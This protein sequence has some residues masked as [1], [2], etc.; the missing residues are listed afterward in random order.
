MKMKKIVSFIC[1]AVISASALPAVGVSAKTNDSWKK[2]YSSF[3]KQ[4]M[5]KSSGEDSDDFIFERG[6]SVQDL[7]SDGIPELMVSDGEWHMAQCSIYTYLGGNKLKKL[8]DFGEYGVAAFSPENGMLVSGYMGMGYSFT[9]FYKLEN[10]KFETIITFDDDAGAVETDPTFKIDGNKVS[11]MYYEKRLNEYLDSTYITVGNTFSLTETDIKCALGGYSSYKTA[12]KKFLSAKIP[13]EESQEVRYFYKKDLTG[14]GVPE[15][16]FS[17]PY[18]ECKIFTYAD[19]R[20]QLLS[21]NYIGY[22]NNSVG[23]DSSAK[24]LCFKGS[25]DYGISYGF[26]SVQDGKISRLCELT[27]YN[28]NNGEPSYLLNSRTVTASAYSSELKKYQGYTFK[29]IGKKYTVSASDISKA[30]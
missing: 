10:N 11:Q 30:F 24:I 29:K 9:G 4:E 25:S 1:A 12:Y 2:A 3:L 8:G 17:S 6:F 7:N 19:G 20:M 28:V 5:K 21:Y 13:E 18:G 22:D 26:Y 14:D 16:I 27:K 15:L 23:Y